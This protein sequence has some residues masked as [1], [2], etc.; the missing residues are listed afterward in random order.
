M[1]KNAAPDIST[2]VLF[3]KNA[4]T[5]IAIFAPLPTFAKN[6]AKLLSSCPPL[7]IV[8]QLAN[9]AHMKTKKNVYANNAIRVALHAALKDNVLSA[10]RVS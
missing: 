3:A 1:L 9:K 6:A 4:L 8:F 2:T 7:T 5:A 10:K